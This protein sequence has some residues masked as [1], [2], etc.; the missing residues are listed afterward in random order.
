MLN[1]LQ[2]PDHGVKRRVGALCNC[3]SVPDRTAIA[4]HHARSM[5]TLIEALP[6]LI[7]QLRRDGSVIRQGGGRELREFSPDGTVAGLSEMNWPSAMIALLKQLTRRAMAARGTTEGSV[8]IAD[9]RYEVRVTA[10]S[11]EIAIGMIRGLSSVAGKDEDR[12]DRRSFWQRLT[13]SIATATLGERA[14]ALALIH[15]DGIGEISQIMDTNVSD[16]LIGVA[17]RRLPKA[18]GRH[19]DTGTWHVGQTGDDELAVVFNHAERDAIEQCLG[20]VCESLRS[21][22]EFGDA[23]FHL[24]VYAGVAILGRDAGSQKALLESARAAL[25]EARRYESTAACFFSDTIKLRALTRLDIAR[26]LRDA[27]ANREITLRYRARHDLKSGK[28]AAMVGYVRWQHPIR[29]NIAPGQFLGAAAATGRAAAL[30]RNLLQ[31]LREDALLMLPRVGDDVRISFG[32]LRHH[33]LD[34]TFIRDV[35]D[36]LKEQAIDASRLELRIAERTHATRDATEWHGLADRGVRFVV[37][38]VGR[39][40]SSL[41]RLAKAPIWGLQLDRGCAAAIDHDATALKI[42]RAVVGMA[43]A[44]QLVPIATAVDSKAQRRSL[45]A[46]GCEQGS[47]DMYDSTGIAGSSAANPRDENKTASLPS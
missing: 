27:L 23:S 35:E 40:S 44:L 9:R 26:E 30:S 34:G 22:L 17:L 8:T 16:Q 13:E 10:Q 7:V 11:P 12:T 39:K 15:L 21:R 29:G 32:A 45:M 18:D 43:R 41:Q 3:R 4:V 19:A 36:A 24:K 46:I 5:D 1:T 6:D 28:L 33:V 20:V 31:Q 42:C 38:E 14:V 25:T 37:D 47:G 2:H